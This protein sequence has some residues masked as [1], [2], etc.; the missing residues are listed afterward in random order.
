MGYN[1]T[2]GDARFEWTA[3]GDFEPS[4]RIVAD[5]VTR[6]DAPDHDSFT[7]KSNS[8]SPSY[9]TWHDVCREAGVYPL[10]FGGGWSRDERRY[11]PPPDD[12]H[13]E[14]PLLARHPGF[15]AIGPKDAAY[16][17]A[18][19]VT[20]MEKHPNAKPGFYD[21]EAS[22]DGSLDPVLA[23][24]VWLDFWFSWAVE[25]CARPIFENT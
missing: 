13:R 24:L 21:D 14:T 2:I 6:A 17:K 16:I 10:F 9:T 1:L 12:F 19:L 15:Q 11:L 5:I 8:R 4:L 18:A 20:Y 23:R 7:G 25:N 3:E 22:D